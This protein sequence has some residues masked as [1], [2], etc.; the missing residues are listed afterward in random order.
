[1][2]VE[3]P[4]LEGLVWLTVRGAAAE[5]TAEVG[6][7]DP[8]LALGREAMVCDAEEAFDGDVDADFFEGF[9]DGAGLKG[10]EV[11][12]FAADDAPVAGF[13]R[14][15]AEGQKD[16]A[17]FVGQKDAYS[18]FGGVR[19]I[20]GGGDCHRIGSFPVASVGDRR[21]PA[22]GDACDTVLT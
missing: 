9:A 22:C 15:F 19:R 20:A 16:A 18:D 4:D 3:P 10:L 14:A 7:G 11:V 5:D 8:V 13:R 1:L 12:Q 2:R 21:R 6:W 17:L